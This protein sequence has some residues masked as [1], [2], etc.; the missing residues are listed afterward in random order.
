MTTRE[1]TA[2][3]W[4]KL[5]RFFTAIYRKDHPLQN[6]AF[7]E[8]Q[9]GDK[10]HGRSFI[11]LNDADKIV[12]HVGANFG[13][14][15]A[16][17]INVY[18]NEE[19]RGKGILGE[20]Y[21]LARQYYPL[22]ATAANEAGLGL[23]RNMR[24]TRYHDLLRYV[25][26]NP[27]IKDKRFENACQHISVDVDNLIIKDTHYFQQPSLKGIILKDGSRAV[28]QENVGGLRVV[29]VENL[30]EMETQAWQLGYLWLDYITSWNDLLIKDIEKSGWILDFKSVIPWR[31][32]PVE[33]DYFCDITFLSEGPLDNSFVMHRSYSDHG[34]IGSLSI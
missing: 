28:S 26:I 34:R 20:L 27:A 33:K 9:Y 16:W 4:E 12:G 3:D 19:C 22:A 2:T 25:K 30:D 1:A 11:C 21:A 14:N 5:E 17:I 24:W 31:L 8:W 32:N 13:G 23:Y 15:I 10:K 18:L 29:S 6:K 7:W